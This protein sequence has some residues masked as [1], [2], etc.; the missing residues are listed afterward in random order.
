[1]STRADASIAERATRHAA[2]G[3]PVRLG[4]VEELASSDRA[5]SEL[6][7]MFGLESNLLAH[8]LDV[9]QRVGLI[10]RVQSTGDQRRRYVR[11]RPQALEGIVP[12]CT[13][14]PAAALFVCSEN[15]AR[16][17]LAAAL[18]RH[19]T[20]LPATSAGTHPAARVHPGA[21]AAAERAGFDLSGAAPRSLDEV[22][23]PP[24]L[25]VT[26]CDRA[27][28]EIAPG[29]DWLHWSVPDPVM[30]GTDAAFDATVDE[31]T[32]RMQT[33]AAAAP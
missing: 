25:V 1:M 22:T 30:V 16:S 19:R 9:L 2:L 33:M 10:E 15:S 4:I 20:G 32:D 8:H 7:R 23:D 27:H 12:G 29:D 13:I 3:D 31:L 26:V 18:W 5:P 28:E 11:L 24:A 14:A 6:R 21:V 17:Q